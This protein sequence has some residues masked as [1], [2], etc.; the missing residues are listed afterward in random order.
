MNNWLYGV[1][2]ALILTV[3]AFAIFFHLGRPTNME[4]QEIRSHQKAR[5]D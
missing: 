5:R 2:I 1:S 4:I 3:I